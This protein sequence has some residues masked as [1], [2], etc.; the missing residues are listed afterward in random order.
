MNNIEQYI[1][2]GTYDEYIDVESFARWQLIHDILGTSDA[3]G[4]NIYMTKYDSSDNSK[5][6]M[7]TP[8]DFDTIYARKD[9]FATVHGGTRM[10]SKWLFESENKAF[11]NSYKNQW[12]LLSANLWSYLSVELAKLENEIG[13]DIN[14][15]REYNNKRWGTNYGSVHDDIWRAKSFILPRINWLNEAINDLE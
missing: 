13:I 3:A 4:S 9:M 5:L 12:N 14:I 2:D 10:Y 7:S 11:L 15:S 6:Y 8:W 1:L